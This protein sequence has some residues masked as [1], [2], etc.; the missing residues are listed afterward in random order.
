MSGYVKFERPFLIRA[1]TGL[2]YYESAAFP[3]GIEDV[4]N[5]HATTT[6][7]RGMAVCMDTTAANITGYFPRWDYSTAGTDVNF[8]TVCRIP[9]IPTSSA[10]DVCLLGVAMENI[11]AGATGRIITDGLTSVL[12][13]SGQCTTIGQAVI[14]STTVG[15]VA[16]SAAPGVGYA[17]GMVVVAACVGAG[18]TG[19][20]TQAFIKIG[21]IPGAV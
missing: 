21:H 9:V 19:S 2:A 17:L 3:Q 15:A 8:A 20:A 16:S 12:C 4:W 5:G 7:T 11:P 1:A 6:I 13:V 14:G 10:T 18:A